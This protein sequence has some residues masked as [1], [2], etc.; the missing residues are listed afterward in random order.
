L[1]RILAGYLG[2]P[3]QSLRFEYGAAGK[4]RLAGDMAH[5][6]AFN[7][8]HSGEWGLCAVTNGFEVGVD[9]E[10]VDMQLDFAKLAARFFSR[11]E[12]SRLEECAPPRRRRLFFRIWTRKE[13]WLKGRGGG[14]SEADQDLGPAHLAGCC[15]HD[16][17]WWL[18]S[19]PVTRHYLAALAVP[20]EVSRVR[21]W[22]G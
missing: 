18:R 21:R 16:R 5:L 9:I 7:L 17:N 20:Q 6:V 19:F 11:N 12:W 2:R 3:P 8:A 10:R 13:A 1:R 15:T 4:P 22:D 14:F